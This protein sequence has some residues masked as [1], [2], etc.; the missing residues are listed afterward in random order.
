MLARVKLMASSERTAPGLVSW[1][2]LANHP[3][4]TVT[5]SLRR[6]ASQREEDGLPRLTVGGSC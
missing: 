5:A 2:A 4:H 1:A 6:P 3:L